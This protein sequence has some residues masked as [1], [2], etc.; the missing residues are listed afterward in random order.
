MSSPILALGVLA[1]PDAT[2]VDSQRIALYSLDGVL[3][4]RP[5]VARTVAALEAAVTRL[6]ALAAAAVSAKQLR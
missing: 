6:E 3:M 5:P 1:G 2:S 4:L